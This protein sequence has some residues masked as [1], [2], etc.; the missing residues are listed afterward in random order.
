MLALLMSVISAVAPG[1]HTVGTGQFSWGEPW[2]MR[3][4]AAPYDQ[5][6]INLVPQQPR[7]RRCPGGP[8]ETY[9]WAN[10][11]ENPCTARAFVYG[12][13]PPATARVTIL[14]RMGRQLPAR[15]RLLP[16]VRSIYFV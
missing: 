5:Q 9:V 3:V 13:L 16:G 1:W 7:E 6:C 10:Y 14:H 2:R 8:A 12:S 11:S 15:V 4:H